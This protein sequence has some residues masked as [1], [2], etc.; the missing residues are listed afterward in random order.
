MQDNSTLMWQNRLESRCNLQGKEAETEW[1]TISEKTER[2][3]SVTSQ[4]LRKF[5]QIIM[6]ND[7]FAPLLNR[8]AKQLL[9]LIARLSHFKTPK[10][11]R[12]LENNCNRT[13]NDPAN[14]SFREEMISFKLAH[15]ANEDIRQRTASELVFPRHCTIVAS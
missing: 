4:S 7:T 11:G 15:T 1:Q 12:K 8:N 3:S 14:W 9:L 5:H 6:T 13:K 10:I 2:K